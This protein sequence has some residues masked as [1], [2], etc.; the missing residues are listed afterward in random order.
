[1]KEKFLLAREG[2]RPCSSGFEVG[3]S[4]FLGI[5]GVGVKEHSTDS[6]ETWESS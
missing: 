2:E 1:M 6:Q 4:A 3:G 5:C